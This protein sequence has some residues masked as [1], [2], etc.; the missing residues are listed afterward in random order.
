MHIEICRALPEQS[1]ALTAIALAAKRYW[2]Y[3][4]R[5]MQL[6]MPELTFSRAYFEEN[7]SWAAVKDGRLIGFCTLQE[8]DENAWLENLW[9]RPESMGQG[10]G[11]T[12]FSHAVELSRGRGF[13]WLRWE[14][15]PHAIGFY[16]KMGG[17][18]IGERRSEVDGETRLLPMM[19][20]EL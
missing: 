18:I 8:K 19:E 5:W 3:P 15:D 1:E 17:H 6:W 16:E 13:R 10:A 9:V 20:L 2:G 11:K 7:E 4:E 14:S 12:M